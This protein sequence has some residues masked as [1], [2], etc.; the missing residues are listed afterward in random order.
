MIYAHCENGNINSLA[1][2][3]RLRMIFRS[4]PFIYNFSYAKAAQ[5]L[6]ISK[7]TA[8]S[9]FK[10]LE[11]LGLISYKDGHCKLLSNVQAKA[12]YKNKKGRTHFS[13]I[14]KLH[15]IEDI[16]TWIQYM[17]VQS[18]LKRQQFAINTKKAHSFKM[19]K[20]TTRYSTERQKVNEQIIL[21][22]KRIGRH[23]GQSKLS[24]LRIQRKLND[25]ELIRSTK[26]FKKT[27]LGV[28]T[29]EMFRHMNLSGQFY[30]FKGE[31]YKRLPN[32]LL[33]RDCTV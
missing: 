24:G 31:V 16:K 21:S 10:R 32:T 19:H 28:I 8:H 15:T 9:V 12:A 18:S 5:I 6:N 26:N 25:V 23:F 2:Y 29:S 1:Y 7:S 27:R 22:N 11:A 33:S 30:M 4:S 20:S 13:P 3:A 17:V 14:K